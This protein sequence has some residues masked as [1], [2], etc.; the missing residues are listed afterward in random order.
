MN[1]KSAKNAYALVFSMAILAGCSSTGSMDDTAGDTAGD[2]TGGAEVS[3]GGDQGGVSSSELEAQKAAEAQA[4]EEAA[5]R[6]VRTFYFDFDQST[7][8]PESRM[9]LTAHAKFLAANPSV[10]VVLEGHADERGTKAYNLAL[11]ERRGTAVERF[12]VVNG[13]AKAQIE[14]VSYGEERPADT[15]STEAAWA[16][17]RRVVINY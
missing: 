11:G 6:E 14:V 4:A 17:N 15:A 3:A 2:Q 5:L 8:K 16:K 1:L 9:P 7:I 12:L 10:K 13:V